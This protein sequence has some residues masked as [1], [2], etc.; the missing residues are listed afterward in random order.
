MFIECDPEV[1]GQ[2]ESLIRSKL[3]LSQAQT[4]SQP[5]QVQAN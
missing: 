4:P 2:I 1:W 5:R 3:P